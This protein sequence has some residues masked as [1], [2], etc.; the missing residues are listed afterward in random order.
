MINIEIHWK[1]FNI[2]LAMIRLECDVL[3]P[4]MIFGISGGSAMTIHCSDETSQEQ[5]D[6][7]T[8]YIDGLTEES[9]E[10]IQYRSQ[11]QVED[12]VNTL[13]EGIPSKTW[14]QLTGPERK[15]ILGQVPTKAELMAA[16]LL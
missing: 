14:N 12:C 6:A 7:I 2:D 3:A 10:C 11:Q 1:S 13:K 5:I 4:N 16:E 15:L 8:E 9:D